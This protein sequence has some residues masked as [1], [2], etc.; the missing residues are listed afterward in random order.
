[1][2][3][4]WDRRL[5]G[6]VGDPDFQAWVVTQACEFVAELLEHSH[7]IDGLCATTPVYAA[8]FPTRLIDQELGLIA[9][10]ERP[11][12]ISFEIEFIRAARNALIDRAEIRG[13][14]EAR[15]RDLSCS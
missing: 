13:L 12:R 5:D 3:N 1:M 10:G 7:S 14:P 4:H 6:R 11:F 9:D 8:E 15:G 2:A